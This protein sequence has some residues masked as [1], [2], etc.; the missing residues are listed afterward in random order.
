L[1]N[2]GGGAGAGEAGAMSG[3]RS[4]LW[5]LLALVGLAGGWAYLARTG[6]E[7][8]LAAFA[9]SLQGRTP[10]QR[11]NALRA[12]A[13]V[14]GVVIPPGGRFSFNGRVGALSR[15]RGYLKAPVSFDGELVPSFGGGVCQTS[16]TV[17]N[18]ALLAGM[19]VTERHRHV[20]PPAYASHGDDAAVAYP[21][22]D[23]AFTNPLPRP[24]RLTCRQEGERL[25]CEIHSTRRP[26]ETYRLEHR[27]QSREAA[28]RVRQPGEGTP[29][30]AG[31][32]IVKGRDGFSVTTLRLTLRDGRLVA[33]EI[34]ATDSYQP[35]P[36]VRQVNA[37]PGG[38]R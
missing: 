9:T 12:A 27:L 29:G 5:V 14:S 10:N 36:E 21:R 8:V 22:V 19:T 23:L 35:L 18:A 20:W 2:E 4:T 28:P 31:R 26:A 3:R 7:V 11:A 25:L 37:D 16:T 24:V 6:R 32:R 13:A 1:L 38:I 30:P 34:I 17:Y 15:D 33:R